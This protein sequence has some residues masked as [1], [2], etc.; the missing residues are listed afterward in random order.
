MKNEK[1]FKNILVLC[2]DFEYR[3]ANDLEKKFKGHPIPS[4]VYKALYDEKEK[5]LRVFLPT[6]DPA[7]FGIKFEDFFG[8][9]D[10]FS[11]SFEEYG[12]DNCFKMSE[13][14]LELLS[15]EEMEEWE[16]G[17]KAYVNEP[18]VI[19][20][21]DMSELTMTVNEL[22]SKEDIFFP[23]IESTLSSLQARSEEI[24]C[25]VVYCVE[26]TVEVLLEGLKLPLN[27][28]LLIEM[29]QEK[30]EILKSSKNADNFK[31]ISAILFALSYLIN[32]E[33]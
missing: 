6:K 1:E 11:Y 19:E 32:K 12:S 18:E 26:D 15:S 17:E 24:L 23:Y 22:I 31:E 3:G 27:Q 2:N 7:T 28:I 14:S 16:L 10:D 29:L 33:K 20:D 9:N 5:D 25:G 30:L 13:A 8:Q 4:I 21:D